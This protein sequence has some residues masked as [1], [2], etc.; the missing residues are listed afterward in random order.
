MELLSEMRETYG[1]SSRIPGIV[2]RFS[3][4]GS[5]GDLRR[6]FAFLAGDNLYIEETETVS[7]RGSI[8]VKG[9]LAVSYTHDS[10]KHAIY[11]RR[12]KEPTKLSLRELVSEKTT[13]MEIEEDVFK[14]MNWNEQIEDC[15]PIVS[16]GDE[17]K[18]TTKNPS[19]IEGSYSFCHRDYVN[20]E[21]LM[22]MMWKRGGIEGFLFKPSRSDVATIDNK[23]KCVLSAQSKLFR[24]I[25]ISISWEGKLENGTIHWYTSSLTLGWEGFG[26]IFDKPAAAEKLR[27]DPWHISVPKDDS[28]GDILCFDREG[29]GHLVFAKETCFSAK[30][31]SQ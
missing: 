27:K 1:D 30:P 2:R 16:S 14:R 24:F 28:T 21:E 5:L 9:D 13:M 22:G 15:V 20:H 17:G 3:Q 7:R 25:P 4:R 8:R 23:G 19:Q 26:K 10:K 31:K 29:K 12:G 11:G 18:S 6:S